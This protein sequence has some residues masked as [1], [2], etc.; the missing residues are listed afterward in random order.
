MKMHRL[1]PEIA[2]G[3]ALTG[4][5]FFA[6]PKLTVSSRAVAQESGSTATA[7]CVVNRSGDE[8]F[9]VARLASGKR[10]SATLSDQQQLCLDG[11]TPGQ[12]G[13][14]SVFADENAYEGC[15][16]L[17]RTGTPQILVDFVE[18]DNCTWAR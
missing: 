18:F 7:L 14:V 12:T 16:R 17:A 8:L 5:A 3:A 11:D 13:T 4:M 10:I 2:I 1:F 9:F 6:M 15:T